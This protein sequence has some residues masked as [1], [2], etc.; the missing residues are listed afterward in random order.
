M[1]VQ[2]L[3]HEQARLKLSDLGLGGLGDAHHRWRVVM[4]TVLKVVLG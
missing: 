3:I 4:T 1:L 2:V